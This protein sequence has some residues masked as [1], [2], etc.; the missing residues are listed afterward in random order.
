MRDQNRISRGTP[1]ADSG[2]RASYFSL[3]ADEQWMRIALEEARAAAEAGEVPVGAVLVGPDGEVVRSRN[4]IR[5]I[6]DPTGHA[7]MIALRHAAATVGDA[8]LRDYTLYVTLEPCAMCAGA[9]VLARLRRLVFGA[10]DPKA[11]M[12][13]SLENLVRDPRL[14][15]RVELLGGVL[16]EECGA[17]L[18]RFFGRLR[19]GR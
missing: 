10:W 3:E 1:E 7:E 17:E 15:H 5:E 16:G 13:G 9:I 11:G 8:R 2:S 14:N 18:R 4:R 12:C 19:G 6:H